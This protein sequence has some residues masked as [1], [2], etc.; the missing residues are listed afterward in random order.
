M[1]YTY[2]VAPRQLRYQ[3][4]VAL[5]EGIGEY[6]IVDEFGLGDDSPDDEVAFGCWR[7]IDRACR[8]EIEAYYDFSRGQ[9]DFAGGVVAA[10]DGITDTDDF[11]SVVEIS[12]KSGDANRQRHIHAIEPKATPPRTRLPRSTGGSSNTRSAISIGM[13][14]SFKRISEFVYAEAIEPALTLLATPEFAKA[15][16]EFMTAHRQYR[17]GEFKDAVERRKSG[18]RDN[19]EV[20]RRL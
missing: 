4:G 17:A 16:A 6:R 3:I 19:A 2:D 12:C 5:K 13:A 11:L 8:K 15:N 20:N 9:E 7:E 18:F 10:L 1:V 14:G